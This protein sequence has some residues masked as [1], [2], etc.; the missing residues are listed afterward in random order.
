MVHVGCV[1]FRLVSVFQVNFFFE[2][3][4]IVDSFHPVKGRV[5]Y[6]VGSTLERVLKV[7]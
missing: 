5:G 4:S 1:V 6:R 3:A 7:G 2:Q